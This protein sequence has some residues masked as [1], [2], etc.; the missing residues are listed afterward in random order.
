M[1]FCEMRRRVRNG[2]SMIE[3]MIVVVIIGVL[4]AAALPTFRKYMMRSKTIEATMNVRKL[5][6]SSVAY[7]E[8]EHTDGSGKVLAKQFPDSA[9][10]SPGAAGSCC[11]QTGDKCAPSPSNFTADTWAALNFNI[12]D[13]FYFVYDYTSAGSDSA[14]NFQA[15]AF[16]DLD[17]DKVYSTYER[18]GSV[19]G[20]RSVSGGA[21]LYTKNEIE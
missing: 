3:L 4:A 11:G 2:F 16:G 13:A 14:A 10:P 19:L 8:A 12:G 18:S 5:F 17:C 9:G 7:F 20:D 1:V 15:W 6:D 21:G